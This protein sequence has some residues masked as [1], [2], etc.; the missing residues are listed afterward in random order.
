MSVGRE[1]DRGGVLLSHGEGE[2][3]GKSPTVMQG[4]RGTGEESY[5]HTG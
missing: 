3:H 5:C 1:R 4:G 2:G